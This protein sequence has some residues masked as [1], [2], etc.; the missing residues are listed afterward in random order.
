MSEVTD[1]SFW[2]KAGVAAIPAA[3]A[4]VK[5]RLARFTGSPQTAALLPAEA[6]TPQ[7]TPIPVPF[8]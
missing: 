6:D 4:V 3:L 7:P 5:G 1:L 2:A 8:R